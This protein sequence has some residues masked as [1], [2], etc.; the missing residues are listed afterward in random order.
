MTGFGTATAD[1]PGGRLAVEVRS[2]NHRYSEIQIRMPRELAGL[3]DRARALVAERVRRGRVEV[4]VTREEGARRARTVRADVELAAGYARALRALA[5]EIGV[6]DQVTLAQIA[7]LPD[8]LRVEEERADAEAL[9]T[10]VEAAIRAAADGLV[11]MRVSEGAR[12]ADDLAGRVGRLEV[13]VDA[14]ARRA[15]EVVRA[16]AERLRARVTEL[17]AQAPVDEARIAN[18]VALFAER[19]DIAEELTRLRSH[20]AQFRQTLTE[21]GGAAGRKLEFLLQEMSRETNTV[22]SKA[23]DLEITRMIIAMKGELESMREQVQNVE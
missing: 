3:E 10:A 13:M 4:I 22:G 18:E 15:P 6:P 11:A 5:S 1:V 9:W 14:V 21:D 19:S 23:N 12:L 17:L 20:L 2:V 16:Y 8:V 7:S